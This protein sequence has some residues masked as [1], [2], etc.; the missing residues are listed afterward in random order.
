MADAEGIERV[1]EIGTGL[2]EAQFWA[3][4]LRRADRHEASWR[5]RA[6]KL[7]ERY[8]DE[9]D[10]DLDRSNRR[11]NIF[12]SNVQT[13][14]PTVYSSPPVPDVRRRYQDDD[15]VGREVAILLERE[16]EFLVDDQPEV[17]SSL[18]EVFEAV[19]D[20]ALI[21]GRG[22]AWVVYEAKIE[23]REDIQVVP[24]ADPL[25]GAPE[26]V[27]YLLDGEPVEPDFGEDG[28][29]FVE[30]KVSESIRVDHVG[31]EDY[32]ESPARCAKDVWWVARRHVMDRDQLVEEF[33]QRGG[34]KQ[35]APLSLS[36]VG[37]F[38]DGDGADGRDAIERIP[39]AFRR[40]E[41]WEIW[42]RR[43]R[44]RIWWAR[45]GRDLLRK[46]DDPLG[47]EGFFPR[48]DPLYAV[49]TTDSRIPVPEFC[50]YQDQAD[51]LDEIATRMAVLI[52]ALKAVA[53]GD[54]TLSELPDVM[55]A[56]DGT[57]IP[58]TRPAAL[59]DRGGLQGSLWFWPIEVIAGVIVGLSQRAAQLK[60]EIQEITGLSD[61]LR[62]STDARET[63]AAQQLKS[64]F[65]QVRMTPRSQPMAR[66]IRDT[67]RIMAEIAAEMF[68]PETLARHTG[69][70]PT[71]EMMAL[72][73]EQR[74]REVRIDVETDSTVRADD[75]R[76]KQE[77]VEYIQAM[78]GFARQAAEIINIMP[79]TA[80]WLLETVRVTARRFKFGRGFEE[81]VDQALQGVLQQASQP[82]QPQPS[83]D[84]VLESQTDLEVA[85]MREETKR[86][87]KQAEIM[88][89]QANRMLGR[90]VAA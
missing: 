83:P 38:G 3:S 28:L 73:R 77:A 10:P 12:W 41:V 33:G 29:P 26:Q 55:A 21:V 64:A 1:S 87:V 65:G 90:Q 4:E 70:E 44:K 51:E 20:D 2:E 88:A 47:L 6:R 18:S 32:R 25:T 39:T 59:S 54:G 81:A 31:W 46:D 53:I 63:A 43:R 35:I 49:R 79:A 52:R 75:Q 7:V 60:Q 5:K 13:I 24:V 45:G 67:L 74:L 8:R 68:E 72:L 16:L 37:S 48:A 22:V 50:L 84:T 71:P 11:F 61:I 23:R 56:S 19:R 34:D 57:I 62:G 69:I 89:D 27:V 36:V 9:R 78:T 66:V 42:D 58:S 30:R 86:A 76:Q 40:A 15:P 80:P 14:A 82:Q 17:G 85:R